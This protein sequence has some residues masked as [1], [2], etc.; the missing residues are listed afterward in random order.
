MRKSSTMYSA[1]VL[2]ALAV[3]AACVAPP[4]LA[5]EPEAQR[6]DDYYAR[7]AY[8]QICTWNRK[9]FPLK[10]FVPTAAASRTDGAQ[11]PLTNYTAA[12]KNAFARWQAASND[13]FTFQFVARQANCDIDCALVNDRSKMSTEWG[14]AE[15]LLLGHGPGGLQHASIRLCTRAIEPVK[16]SPE[17]TLAKL[18][19]VALHEVGHSLGLAGHSDDQNDIMYYAASP[20]K[21]NQGPSARDLATLNRL[22]EPAAKPIVEIVAEL[23]RQANQLIAAKRFGEAKHKIAQALQYD[24]C[25]PML[26]RDAARCLQQEVQQLIGQAKYNQALSVLQEQNTLPIDTESQASRIVVL[27]NLAAVYQRLGNLHA[28]SSAL[29]SLIVILERNGRLA[30]AR[31]AQGALDDM[32]AA[33]E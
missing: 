17:E 9:K 19:V 28:A 33:T 25:S 20:T 1:A 14:L 23:D 5:D 16:L 3:L 8:E 7:V 11:L 22:Y 6:H 2:A 10:V 18:K 12:L 4:L 24:R 21:G 29:R 30:E 27:R 15:T 31:A 13:R 26:E 32:L